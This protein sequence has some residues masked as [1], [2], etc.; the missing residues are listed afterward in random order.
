MRRLL[1]RWFA[2]PVLGAILT[3]PPAGCHFDSSRLAELA[4]TEGAAESCPTGKRCCSGHCVL[5]ASCPDAGTDGPPPADLG[6]DLDPANDR[7][8]DGV[9]N[10]EDNCPDTANPSQ[11]DGDQDGL[12]DLCDCAPADSAFGPPL[13]NIARFTDPAPFDPVEQASSWKV[14]GGYYQQAST[15]G[16]NR[17]AHESI[18]PQDDLLVLAVIRFTGRGD[19]GLVFDDGE[20]NNA[21]LAGVVV[22]T[23][24]LSANAGGGYYCAL[25]QQNV[26]LVSGRTQGSDLASDKL[27]LFGDTTGPGSGIIRPIREDTPY[28]ITM[29]IVDDQISCRALLADLSQVETN[30]QDKTLTTGGMALFT[31]GASALFESVKVCGRN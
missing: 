12:G 3:A 4:C 10:A 26:R 23:A 19:D 27:E 14:L 8:L 9:A 29:R 2:M 31:A 7:D 20:D 15:N 5:V 1:L 6:P 30:A 24:G 11:A 25:D 13:A 17:A 28:T 21:S 16:L 22:R 18:S